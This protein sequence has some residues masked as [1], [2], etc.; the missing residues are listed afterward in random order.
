MLQLHLQN[1]DLLKEQVVFA[2]NRVAKTIEEKQALVEILESISKP[3]SETLAIIGRIYK[4]CWSISVDQEDEI[5]QKYFLNNAIYNY[6]QASYLDTRDTYPAINYATLLR[7][8]S[9]RGDLA[10]MRSVLDCLHYNL[11]V[12]TTV[13]DPESFAE[14][15]K[16]IGIK[17][18]AKR[19]ADYWD[20]ATAFEMYVLRGH[21]D[22]VWQ[23]KEQLIN[24]CTEKWML[25]TTLNNLI[26]LCQHDTCSP[27]WLITII[28]SLTAALTAF[29]KQGHN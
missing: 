5:Q 3:S 20:T 24:R 17:H 22:Q 12:T 14:L 18:I 6:Q 25:A 19:T 15:D 21:Q 2:R 16:L 26:L 11:K 23:L 7:I 10:E 8:R 27:T 13:F 4:D 29:D 9:N 28:E 1:L